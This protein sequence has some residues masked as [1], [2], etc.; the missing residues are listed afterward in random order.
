M[1]TIQYEVTIGMEIHAELATKTK[2]FCGCLNA[3]FDS[4]AGG[5]PN[6]NVCPVCLALPGS[7]PVMN[8]QAI[9]WA[10]DLGFDLGSKIAEFTKWDRKNYFYPDLPKGYQ[11]S[12]YDLPLLTGGAIEFKLD[13][14]IRKINLTRVHLEEDTGKLVHSSSGRESL[15]DFNRA[16]VPLLELVTEP[17]LHSAEE[18]KKLCQTYQF[19]LQRRGI[20]RADM[21][22]GEMRC[23]ANISISQKSKVKS[24]KLGTKVE[25]KNL[26]SFRAVER[27]IKYEVER[28][29]ETLDAGG[30]VEQETRGWDDAKQQTYVQRKK[31]TAADY[32]YFPEPDLPPVTP[33]NLWDLV[34]KERDALPYPH[35]EAAEVIH[36]FGLPAEVAELFTTNAE[37][38]AYWAELREELAEPTTEQL[39]QLQLAASVYANL[40][41]ARQLNPTQLVELA[42]LVVVGA[43]SQ[44]Q[45]RE[46]VAVVIERGLEPSEVVDQLGLKQ[47]SDQGE[48]EAIVDQVLGEQSEVV[49]KYRSGKSEVYGFLFGQVMRVSRGKANPAIIGEILKRMLKEG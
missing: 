28:Q 25:V 3:P 36:E 2:M 39:K 8:R 32:R 30:Q 29:I 34:A 26:N 16:G 17:E 42:G 12:Q 46:V 44:S 1:A 48:V 18:A 7:L 37:A 6:A 5:G 43:I 15:V 4:P 11:I 27:A 45:I 31:E 22:K 38:F 24:Q 10:V 40:D 19:I 23:E 41:L 20:A 13:N 21:E 9:E 35:E 47:I 49:A 14:E 33:A